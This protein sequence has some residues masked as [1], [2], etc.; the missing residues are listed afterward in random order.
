MILTGRFVY[1]S[2]QHQDSTGEEVEGWADT[3]NFRKHFRDGVIICDDRNAAPCPI[4]TH[5]FHP[6]PSPA[7]ACTAGRRMREWS[8]ARCNTIKDNINERHTS[9]ITTIMVWGTWLSV[10]G[11]TATGVFT[12]ASPLPLCCLRP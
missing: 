4:P 8:E 11:S 7:A 2:H 10:S 1:C 9:T 3:L 6:L 12:I 5:L